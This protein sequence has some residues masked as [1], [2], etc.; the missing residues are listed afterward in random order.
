MFVRAADHK[1][2]EELKDCPFCGQAGE[3]D[4]NDFHCPECGTFWYVEPEE[5]VDPMDEAD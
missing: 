4:G 1:E 3:Q 5:L 2:R